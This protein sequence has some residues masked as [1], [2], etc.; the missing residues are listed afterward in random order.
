VIQFSVAFLQVDTK[1]ALAQGA[2]ELAPVVPT[3][4]QA[5]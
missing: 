5:I 3:P 1:E 4:C 2:T